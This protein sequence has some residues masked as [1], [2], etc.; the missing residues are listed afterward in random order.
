M[1]DSSDPKTKLLKRCEFSR[2]LAARINDVILSDLPDDYEQLTVY[3][4]RL[5][6]CSSQGNQWHATDLHTPAGEC[7][8]GAGR[9]WHCGLKLCSYCVAKTSRA[10]RKHLRNVIEQQR[11]RPGEDLQMITLT[12]I[13][14][15]LPLLTARSILNTA[16]ELF[17]KKNWFRQTIVGGCKSEEFTLTKLGY[18]YHC[19]V[20]V[21]CKSIHWRVMRYYWTLAV[22]SSFGRHGQVF[23]CK[24]SDGLMNARADKITSVE[25]G[26]REVAKYITTSDTWSDIPK[27]DLLDI[28]RI[29]RFP[30][31][32]EMFGSFRI[33][34]A[35]RFAS[36]EQRNSDKTILGTK[37]L[38]DELI[39]SG[40]R[41]KTAN[42]GA[43]KYLKA[44]H[45][46]IVEQSIYRIAQLRH[47]YPT[48]IRYR[49]P[50][51]G[52][53]YYARVLLRLDLIHAA[54]LRLEPISIPYRQHFRPG[55]GWMD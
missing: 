14:K 32:F 42:F 10:N 50:D 41:A 27:S 2:D 13:N 16:W 24:N 37:V 15:G 39:E 17:R 1:P 6:M 25:E 52:V 53:D 31:M 4:H 28:C 7:Y 51:T 9:F 22:E 40:W 33:P 8:D 26:I 43:A 23:H 35:S 12:I 44:L 45:D 20:L 46:E 34:S 11:L 5:L 29:K 30:R 3:A 21:R 18:H 38:S 48:A 36:A 19:H 47:K 54:K 49:V 55:V